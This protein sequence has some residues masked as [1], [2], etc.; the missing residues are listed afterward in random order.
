[1]ANYLITKFK[2]PNKEAYALS[3][4]G[5]KDV[6]VEMTSTLNSKL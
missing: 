6:F 4:V 2:T 5:L 1:M 3:F